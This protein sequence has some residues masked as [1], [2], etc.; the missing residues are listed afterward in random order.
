MI[1][2]SQGRFFLSPQQKLRL[3]QTGFLVFSLSQWVFR[4]CFCFLG[5]PSIDYGFKKGTLHNLEGCKQFQCPTLLKPY[6]LVAECLIK[7][8]K[9]GRCPSVTSVSVHHS[10]LNSLATFVLQEFLFLQAQ[11]CISRDVSFYPAFVGSLF[12]DIFQVL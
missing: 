12:K 10:D 1:I 8:Y 9:N 7:D 5:N 2:N 6:L 4:F 11:L 3:T